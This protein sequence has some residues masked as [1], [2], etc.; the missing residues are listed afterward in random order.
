MQTQSYTGGDGTEQTL[1]HVTEA[2]E[3]DQKPAKH[4]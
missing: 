4:E 2:A 3:P 1:N